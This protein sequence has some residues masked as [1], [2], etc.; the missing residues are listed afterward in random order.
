MTTTT[1]TTI[2]PRPEMSNDE[3]QALATNP[4][5]LASV[6]KEQAADIFAAIDEASLTVEEGQAIVEAVQNA[7]VEVRQ[8][9]EENINVFGG[10]TDTYVP[11]GSR[12][13]VRTRR[14]LIITTSMLVVMPPRRKVN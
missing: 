12:V 10:A 2:V 14:V 3:A 7:P 6:T 5:V 11:L 8:A 9:F 1:S 4:E 13:P